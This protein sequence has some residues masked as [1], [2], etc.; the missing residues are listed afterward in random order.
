MEVAKGNVP[1]HSSV[2]KFGFNPD[3]DN[4]SEPETVWSAG[5]LYPWDSFNTAQTLYVKSS[6]SNDTMAVT[7]EGLDS[8]YDLLSENVTLTGTTAV[9]T[10]NQFIRVF[11]MAYDGGDPN[12]GDI[13]AHVGS[14]TG[15]VVAQI[16]EGL[17]QTLMALYTI[18]AGH[19]G[20]LLTLDISV[21]K[22]KDAQVKLFARQPNKTFRVQQVAEVHEAS[23]TY[24]F[25]IP[26]RFPEKTD[27]EI[28]AH[29]VENNNTR[30]TS[31]FDL[32]LIQDD[33]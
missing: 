16:D 19:T 30:V 28:Q 18:P 33:F 25:P 6:D 5:G 8:N 9:T 15:T 12:E 26:L 4:N 17:A 3:I 2:H 1:G 7:I 10:T 13:T 11:R 21:Q 20:Y 32:L 27:L 29:D 22:N 31:N 24:P 23:K 14:S